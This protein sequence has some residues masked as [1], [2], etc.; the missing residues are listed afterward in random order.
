MNKL[1]LWGIIIVIAMLGATFLSVG[2]SK[3]GLNSD[4]VNMLA[5]AGAIAIFTITV[6]VVIKYVRQMQMDNASGELADENW[7]G[8]GEYKTNCLWVGQ[9]CFCSL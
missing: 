8:I 2:T 9:L 5:I 4:I 7:D 6:F 1:Y 3:G